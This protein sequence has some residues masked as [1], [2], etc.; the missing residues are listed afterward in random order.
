M[1]CIVAIVSDS[2]SIVMGCDRAATNDDA[3][4]VY[5]KTKIFQNGQ[6][7][8]GFSGSF[9]NAQIV[10]YEFKM[11]DRPY[12]LSTMEYMVSYFVHD[13]KKVLK[14]S[15]SIETVNGVTSLDCELVVAYNG[16]L[17]TIMS[18]FHVAELKQ[19]YTC[20]GSGAQAALGALFALKEDGNYSAYDSAHLALKAASR[21]TTTVN[22]PFYVIETYV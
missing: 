6:A 1:T 10:E 4:L 15:E 14:K 16:R 19:N 3:L 21:C 9:R 8:I 13:L 22:G 20:I 11:P 12:G 18:D 2:G 7:L 17:F 5:K